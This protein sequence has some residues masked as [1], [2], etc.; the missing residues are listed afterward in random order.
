MQTAKHY[1]VKKTPKLP[2]SS[3]HPVRIPTRAA[4][5]PISIYHPKMNSTNCDAHYVLF[6]FRLYVHFRM[7]NTL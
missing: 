2:P 1:I 5:Q 6:Y 3:L 4:Y 7:S